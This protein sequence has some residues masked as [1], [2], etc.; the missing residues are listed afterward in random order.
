MVKLLILI[1]GL[2]LARESSA[3]SSANDEYEDISNLFRLGRS[4]EFWEFKIFEHLN[5]YI[6]TQYNRI[7]F[8]PYQD[9]FW[10]RKQALTGSLDTLHASLRV[11]PWVLGFSGLLR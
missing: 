11:V 10:N 2:D 3:F 7:P 1:I 6:L 8:F 4:T 5:L 9:L